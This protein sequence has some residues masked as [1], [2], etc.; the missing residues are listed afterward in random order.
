MF[1]LFYF[2]FFYFSILFYCFILVFFVVLY[3]SYF[4]FPISL[5]VSLF[6]SS[7]FLH[8]I[9][10]RFMKWH[11]MKT[12]WSRTDKG[13]K[14]NH[15]GRGLR[16]PC[17]SVVCYIK[18][19]EIYIF[20]MFHMSHERPWSKL[21]FWTKNMAQALLCFHVIITSKGHQLTFYTMIV[22]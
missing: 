16:Y 11:Q 20:Y 9:T 19:R 8:F 12:T 21:Y 13:I 1:V 4:H 22:D 5:K 3:F 2:L 7:T 18:R 10:F 17:A 14:I 6:L 15:N